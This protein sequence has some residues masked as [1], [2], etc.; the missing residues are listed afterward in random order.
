MR[1]HREGQ[2]IP[3]TEGVVR[4]ADVEA[5]LRPN[6]VG[7]EPKPAPLA[8]TPKQARL[9]MSNQY[10][11]D[12]PPD[13]EASVVDSPE[14][15]AR[16]LGLRPDDFDSGVPIGSMPEGVHYKP[17]AR[18]KI[19]PRPEP[20]RATSPP[21]AGDDVTRA[22]LAIDFRAHAKKVAEVAASAKASGDAAREA[23]AAAGVRASAEIGEA[24]KAK[25]I[26]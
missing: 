25:G 24:L 16:V 6:G 22:Q 1:A 13:W 19:D 18:V 23:R 3:G 20:K 2:P 5:V 12:G 8:L 15:V 4:A 10:V 9:K 26:L 17:G 11:G 21:A 14:T 7:G